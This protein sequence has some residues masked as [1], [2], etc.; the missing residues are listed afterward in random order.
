MLNDAKSSCL[1][2]VFQ[3]VNFLY[4]LYFEAVEQSVKFRYLYKIDLLF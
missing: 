2:N 1:I 3:L 4:Q